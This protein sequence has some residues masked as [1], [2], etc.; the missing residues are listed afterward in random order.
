MNT[1][2]SQAISITAGRVYRGLKRSAEMNAR[3]IAETA[4]P[5]RIE[6]AISDVCSEGDIS[7]WAE[8]AIQTGRQWVRF[9]N[10]VARK[11]QRLITY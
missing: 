2:R 6:R 5:E 8:T 1:L 4:T 9:E 11:V 10:E 7:D 3:T